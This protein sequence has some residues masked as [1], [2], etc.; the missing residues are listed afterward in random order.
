MTEYT[1]SNYY[2]AYNMSVV[3]MRKITLAITGRPHR[4]DNTRSDCQF[5]A[6]K[7]GFASDC[8]GNRLYIDIIASTAISDKDNMIKLKLLN[9]KNQ[10]EYFLNSCMQELWINLMEYEEKKL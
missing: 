6:F 5:S 4:L 8:K 1:V 7:S 9:N 3:V 2:I 10:K